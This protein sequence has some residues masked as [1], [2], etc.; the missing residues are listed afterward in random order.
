M[1]RPT[2]YRQCSLIKRL[3]NSTVEQ[4]TYI[5]EE[6]ARP[7]AAVKLQGEDGWVVQTVGELVD[8]ATVQKRSRL[9]MNVHTEVIDD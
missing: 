5:P 1:A 3:P 2:H 4:T 7:G 6:F 9:Y 8:A